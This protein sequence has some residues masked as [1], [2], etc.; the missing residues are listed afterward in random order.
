MTSTVSSQMGRRWLTAHQ[1]ATTS[2]ETDEGV[3][4]A[5]TTSTQTHQQTV[6]HP[7]ANSFQQILSDVP[8]ET[9]NVELTKTLN[10][11]F[12]NT[13]ADAMLESMAGLPAMHNLKVPQPKVDST[14]AT[15][16]PR[17]ATE[18]IYHQ[19]HGT[20]GFPSV[21]TIN[22]LELPTV[23]N[24]INNANFSSGTDHQ[25]VFVNVPNVAGGEQTKVSD[26]SGMKIV[27]LYDDAESLNSPNIVQET[28]PL[29]NDTPMDAAESDSDDRAE[30]VEIKTLVDSIFER[31]PL[32]ASSV[33][34][35]L[36]T[37][38]NPHVD[39]TCARV[40]AA[41]AERN[42]GNVLL[43][44]ADVE[45]RRL[46]RASSLTEQSGYAECINRNQPWQEKIVSQNNSSFGF[47]P[48]GTCDMDRWN[49]KQ[50]LRTTVAEMKGTYQFVCVS[51]GSTHAK[52]AK[53]W[54]DV[55]DGTYLVVSLKS[56][57]ETY[58]QSSVEELKAHGARLLG[59]VVTD[60][61]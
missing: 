4:A 53:L 18:A 1:P 29:P 44:D 26:T 40:A 27:G 5:Q 56:S 24:S 34:L 7:L 20:D 37:E 2:F 51:A 43:V 50:L 6:R 9:V 8:N 28:A 13:P 46:T 32:A 58:A 10:E 39:E 45:G 49:A 36:G 47:L 19:L 52:H 17:F 59:C 42:V 23:N 22:A 60:V 3:T 38:L 11:S 35:F 54:F 25:I 41:I 16:V 57:N 55:C 14:S 61:E 48:A 21:E 33:L 30:D 15:P 12:E 31:F